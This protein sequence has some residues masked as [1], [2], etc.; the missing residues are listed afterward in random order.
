MAVFVQF[1]DNRGHE[2]RF[3]VEQGMMRDASGVGKLHREPGAVAVGF[4]GDQFQAGTS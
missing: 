3:T 4:I 1:G 2:G